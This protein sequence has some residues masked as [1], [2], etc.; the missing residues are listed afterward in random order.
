MGK[1]ARPESAAKLS[2]ET[3]SQRALEA[4]VPISLCGE[5]YRFDRK[6]IGIVFAE[7][8]N[9]GGAMGKNADDR[10]QTS[11][12]QPEQQGLHAIFSDMWFFPALFF[13]MFG[14]SLPIIALMHSVGVLHNFVAPIQAIIDAYHD[15]MSKF[16]AIVEPHLMPFV[17]WFSELFGLHLNLHPH[18]RHLLI[19]ALIYPMALARSFFRT[20]EYKGVA[21]ALIAW[22]PFTFFGALFSGLVSLQGGWWAQGLIAGV[23]TGAS[24]VGLCFMN[25]INFLVF[26]G[27][28]VGLEFF[29][30]W[31]KWVLIIT[32]ASF[33]L[34][35]SLFFI[36][37]IGA[38]SGLLA[39]AIV[40]LYFGLEMCVRGWYTS[41]FQLIGTGLP[42]LSGF[43]GTG[44]V[45]LA[46]WVLKTYMHVT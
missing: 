21:T 33:F 10:E 45:F 43:V 28:V 8:R 15:G 14:G 12:E 35:A 44:L 29:Q 2:F 31:A 32:A 34:A 1:P 19:L 9:D 40:V 39:L 16:G 37:G 42:M 20:S 7:F 41:V 3:R 22:A 11:A 36:P 5:V 46:D 25:V 30:L 38:F 26:D 23:T 4:A 24:A 13:T 17:H 6:E 18:W 27:K